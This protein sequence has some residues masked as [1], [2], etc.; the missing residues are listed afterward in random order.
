[1]VN[2]P[3]CRYG[4]LHR[5]EARGKNHVRVAMPNL[6]PAASGSNKASV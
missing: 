6:S 5:R 2:V 3:V 4:Q 1:M